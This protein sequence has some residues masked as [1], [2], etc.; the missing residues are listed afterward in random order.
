MDAARQVARRLTILYDVRGPREGPTTDEVVRHVATTL[1]GAGYQT[2]AL[3]VF[4]DL[5]VLADNMRR[6]RPDLVVNLVQ[7]F[8]G[9]PRLAPDVAAVLELLDVPFTGSGP[10]GLY[11]AHD[12]ELA[13]RLLS[14][15]GTAVAAEPADP[16]AT[17]QIVAVLGNEPIEVL[18]VGNARRGVPEEI[19]EAARGAFSA[20]R[21]RDYALLLLRTSSDGRVAIR[22]AVPNPPLGPEDDLAR[23]ARQAGM[24]YDVLLRRIVDESLRRHEGAGRLAPSPST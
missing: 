14:S 3:G 21:L 16:R 6:R 24:R 19:L 1:A 7:R 15:H 2:T 22:R 8:A 20:L 11:L 12:V 5:D 9:N 23:A 18:P 13:T 4:D 17:E 10:A